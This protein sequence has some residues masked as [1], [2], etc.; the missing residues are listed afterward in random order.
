[1][2][3]LDNIIRYRYCLQACNRRDT[4]EMRACIAATSMND[5][6]AM[7]D[8]ACLSISYDD[9]LNNICAVWIRDLS[10]TYDTDVP[11]IADIY[12]HS[13]LDAYCAYIVHERAHFATTVTSLSAYRMEHIANIVRILQNGSLRYMKHSK[14]PSDVSEDHQRDYCEIITVYES[15]LHHVGK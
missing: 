15:T 3:F 7:H 6:M 13:M 10:I 4:N 1:M 11:S 12:L 5:D 8:T 14:L 2:L 9:F